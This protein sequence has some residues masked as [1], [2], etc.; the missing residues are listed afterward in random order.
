MTLR[1][2]WNTSP[3][4]KARRVQES[5]SFS[6]NSCRYHIVWIRLGLTRSSVDQEK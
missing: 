4:P 1:A 3:M 5:A 2:T 6:R